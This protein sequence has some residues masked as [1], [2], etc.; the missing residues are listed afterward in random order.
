MIEEVIQD[1]FNGYQM[2][3]TKLIKNAFHQDTKLLSVD[4]GKLDVTEMKDWLKGL[5]ER[6]LRGDI[7]KGKL[8]IQSIDMTKDTAVVKLGITFEKFGFTDYLSLLQIDGKWI[9]VGKIYYYQPFEN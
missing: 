3:D 6:K 2:A 4:G 8:Q 9:I 7:R 1:Y 5:E